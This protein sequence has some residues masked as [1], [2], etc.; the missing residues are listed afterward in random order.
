MR[1]RFQIGTNQPPATIFTISSRSPAL[2]LAPG[3]FRRRNRLAVVL[4]HHAARQKSCATRNSSIEHG[5]FG[6]DGLTVGDDNRIHGLITS[7]QDR[8]IHAVNAASQSF[9]TGS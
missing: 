5:S 7:W 9:H 4:H 3:K 1:S 2:K 8:L 6:F